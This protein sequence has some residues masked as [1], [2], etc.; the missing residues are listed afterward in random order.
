MV[1]TVRGPPQ[2]ACEKFQRFRS[3]QLSESDSRHFTFYH[4]LHLHL[5][6]WWSDARCRWSDSFSTYSSLC[7]PKKCR[8]RR[9][10]I[11]PHSGHWN[12]LM[13][14]QCTVFQDQISNMLLKPQKLLFLGHT[15]YQEE[16]RTRYNHCFWSASSAAIASRFWEV[17]C[18]VVVY[19]YRHA[20]ILIVQV[21]SSLFEIHLFCHWVCS[22]HASR[23]RPSL[24]Y[25][26][27]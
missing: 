13:E 9:Y 6:P 19:E 1:G 15:Q 16:N 26:E 10:L 23:G 4:S 20:H 5:R 3:M 17:L 25:P 24:D 8:E 14:R 18:R 21:V 2:N 27:I 11:M 22:A 12:F 7:Q